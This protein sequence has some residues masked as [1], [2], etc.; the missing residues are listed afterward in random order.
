VHL[1]MLFVYCFHLLS[2]LLVL[3]ARRDAE[4]VPRVAQ[5]GAGWALSLIFNW[6][7]S[8]VIDMMYTVHHGASRCIT[9]RD[10]T[11]RQP[12][13]DSRMRTTKDVQNIIKSREF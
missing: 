10:S 9:V 11:N 3:A 7:I 4:E 2:Q 6:A 8:V 13:K 12:L 5:G 1:A